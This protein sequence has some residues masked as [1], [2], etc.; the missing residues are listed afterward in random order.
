ME[1]LPCR[2]CVTFS[3]NRK[4]DQVLLVESLSLFFNKMLLHQR[5]KL[6]PTKVIII[7]VWRVSFR[8]KMVCSGYILW[9]KVPKHV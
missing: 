3:D 2:D 6:Y 7:R 8:N 4:S 5:S 1:S 9:K